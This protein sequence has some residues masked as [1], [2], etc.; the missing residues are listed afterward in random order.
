MHPPD[1]GNSSF[2]VSIARD[3]V[4]PAV[5]SLKTVFKVAKYRGIFSAEFKL[6]DRDG[7]FKLIEVNCRPWWLVEFAAV[8]GVDVVE[9]AYMDAL[10][11]RPRPRALDYDVGA[12]YV[13]PYYDYLAIKRLPVGERPGI[14]EWLELAARSKQSIWTRD[15]PLPWFAGWWRL[16]T[17]WLGARLWGR[18]R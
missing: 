4:R 14:L 1:F 16:G 11:H 6:D 2:V 15:D 13:N 8:C 18:P 10:G 9:M 5:E 12:T 3:R 7:V 17:R